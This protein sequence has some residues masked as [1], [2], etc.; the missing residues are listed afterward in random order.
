MITLE[1]YVLTNI[2]IKTNQFV[3]RLKDKKQYLVNKNKCGYFIEKDD[4]C[5]FLSKEV[6][7]AYI[8]SVREYQVSGI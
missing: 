8:S 3:I 1:D 6:I 2:N 7:K 4:K 5:L